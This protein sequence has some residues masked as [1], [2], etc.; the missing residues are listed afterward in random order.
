MIYETD[1]GKLHQWD[2][3]DV[4]WPIESGS[5]QCCVTSPPY[6]NLRDYGVV[7]QLGLEKVMDCLGWATGSDCGKCYVCRMRSVM[8]EL[9]RVLRGDGC[10]FWNIGDAYTSGGR[11]GHGTREGYKQQTNRGSNGTNDSERPV[12][13]T[14]LKPKDLCLIPFRLALA[15]QADGW[16]VRS[17]ICWAKMSPM[18]ESCTD[19]PTSAWEHV[20]LLTKSAKYYYDAEAVKSPS[21][22][23]T[24]KE[25]DGWDT[26]M[27]NGSHGS[28]HKDG[29]SKGRR[30]DKRRGHG[31]RHAGFNDRWDAMQKAE[32]QASGANLRNFWHLGPEP[33]NWDF[34]LAC[35]R[36]YMGK[37]RGNLSHRLEIKDGREVYI[38]VCKCGCEDAWHDHYATFPTEIPRKAIKAGTSEKGCCADCGAPWE[39]VVDRTFDG[40][41]NVAEAQQQ[42][43]NYVSG[44]VDR[45]TL[46]GRTKDV[47]TK[48]TGWRPGCSCDAGV[49]PCTVLD[50]FAGSGTSL[51]VAQNLNRRWVGLELSQD[52]CGLIRKRLENRA[53]QRMLI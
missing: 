25:P 13:P 26:S 45:V 33:T 43:R 24:T 18:P 14:G 37:D 29:R 5:V 21:R 4:P 7:G 44:G 16:Y 38:P 42:R 10:V 39:R 28:I 41:Y 40:E 53:A 51:E 6:W 34:C 35:G 47:K 17:D 2:V 22:A 52:Y 50:C 36:F 11:T 27:G 8:R 23:S 49:V 19:R 32:Q 15:L 31:R 9:W 30:T 20:F 1:L 46:G 3:L 48:T 12:Q